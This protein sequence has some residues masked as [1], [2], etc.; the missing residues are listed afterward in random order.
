MQ[1]RVY[2][3][4]VRAVTNNSR[5]GPNLTLSRLRTCRPASPCRPWRGI[6]S[7]AA[8]LVRQIAIR[9]DVAEQSNERAGEHEG[10]QFVQ[11]WTERA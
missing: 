3:V 1:A 4:R 7:G 9:A 5:K 6:L 11:D 8:S 10:V 2:R